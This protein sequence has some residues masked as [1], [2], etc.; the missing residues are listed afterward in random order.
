[1]RRII[2]ALATFAVASLAVASTATGGVVQHKK[3]PIDVTFQ[4][5][6]L[7]AYCGFEVDIVITGTANVTLFTDQD[8]VVVR[9]LDTQPGSRFGFASP[10]TGKSF[11]FPN[12]LSLH[13]EY[14]EGA[15]PGA[16]AVWRLTGLFE[17]APGVPPEA[18]MAAGE[19]IVL[20]ISPEG[21][22]VIEL[23]TWL[24]ERGNREVG[25]PDAICTALS[26]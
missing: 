25:P 21:I 23:T 19:G 12:S 14:P 26:A 8:G 13:T 16:D 18:G 15:S 5:P 24:V 2:A 22:P 9:E 20:F 10:D 7:S 1:M 17:N 11:S 4:A 6:F 3:L